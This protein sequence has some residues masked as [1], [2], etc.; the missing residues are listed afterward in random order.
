M[1]AGEFLA[2]FND[3]GVQESNAAAERV[4]FSL[5]IVE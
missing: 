1:Q 2:S 3:F 5:M 4:A